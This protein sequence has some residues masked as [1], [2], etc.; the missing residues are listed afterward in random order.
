MA[1]SSG[2]RVTITLGRSGQVVKRAGPVLDSGFSDTRP[3]IGS[4]RSV[5]DRLGSDF[6][7]I[8][9]NTKRQR[10]DGNRLNISRANG[11]DDMRLAKDDLRFKLM[12]KKLLRR[13]QSDG[14]RNGMDLRETLSRTM[15][16]STTSLNS[17]QRVAEPADT[18]QLVSER[19]DVSIMGRIPSR[20]S[21]DGLPQ[22]NLLRDPYS[23][24][25][26]DRL[27]QRSPDRLLS[28]SRNLSPPPRNVEEVMKRPLMRT[29]DDTRTVP[30][31][32]RDILEPGRSVGTATYGTRP[33]VTATAIKPVVP[34]P[35][36]V[37]PPPQS[38][39]LNKS[40]YMSNEHVTVEGFLRS[41]NLDKY[42]INFKAEEVDMTALKQMRDND[43]KEL[44]IPMGPRKKILLALM[45]RSKQQL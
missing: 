45:S 36:P 21:A 27:K 14:Q 11:L 25:G 23:S 19:K 42:V 32:S 6:D 7:G 8:N 4:K 13:V 22:M 3:T 28:S 15:Q 10:E 37:P 24:W 39:V 43:L 29:Y 12:Q 35:V 40:S 18:R 31:M 26:S 30:Y 5:R 44:G 33:T 41:L 34:P 17:R 20:R 38:S 9:L 16:P 1:E 2:S